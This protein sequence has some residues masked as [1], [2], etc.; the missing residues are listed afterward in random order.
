MENKNGKKDK[1]KK[2]PDPSKKD[3]LEKENENKQQPEK[4]ELP[5][6]TQVPLDPGAGVG[7]SNN[8]N[9][10]ENPIE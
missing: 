4:K 8:P 7:K 3:P 6:Q 2:I 5:D 1:E 9:L 10:N